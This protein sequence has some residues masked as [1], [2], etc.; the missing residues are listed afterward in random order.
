MTPSGLSLLP[1][2]PLHT[3]FLPSF[4]PSTYTLPS[5]LPPLHLNSIPANVPPTQTNYSP[6]CRKKRRSVRAAPLCG[7]RLYTGHP[8]IK[9]LAQLWLDA[10]RG[11]DYANYLLGLLACLYG[12]PLTPRLPFPLTNIFLLIPS[13]LHFFVVF[14]LLLF[15]ILSFSALSWGLDGCQPYLC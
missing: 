11:N 12:Y 7:T 6:E 8:D 2:L 9:V 3:P 5:S 13:F 15:L 14:A 10:W 4:V 1:H